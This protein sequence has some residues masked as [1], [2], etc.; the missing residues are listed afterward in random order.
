MLE[1][2]DGE[3]EREHQLAEEPR[4]SLEEPLCIGVLRERSQA[5]TEP[6]RLRPQELRRATGRY[7]VDE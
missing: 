7:L 4:G 1:L 6:Q 2:R 3:V 5:G